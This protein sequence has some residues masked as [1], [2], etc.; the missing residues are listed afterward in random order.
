M[1]GEKA[2]TISTHSLM[3]LILNMFPMRLNTKRHFYKVYRG[4]SGTVATSPSPTFERLKQ[5]QNMNV[6][7][8][9]V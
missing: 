9:L 2:F 6:H 1:F 8:L 4:K 5:Q 7:G 3:C